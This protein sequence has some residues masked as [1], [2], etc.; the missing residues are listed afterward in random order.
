MD[1]PGGPDRVW[2]SIKELANSYAR[3][4]EPPPQGQ[5]ERDLQRIIHENLGRDID[6]RL[7]AFY[8]RELQQLT[9]DA[10]APRT[11]HGEVE[12]EGNGTKPQR[13]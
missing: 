3:L 4:P 10:R 1:V 11:I 9:S 2:R 13:R 6:R 5:M 7:I 8:I 12:P